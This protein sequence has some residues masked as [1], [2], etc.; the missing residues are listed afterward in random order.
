MMKLAQCKIR[1]LARLMLA[2]VLFAHGIVAAS[3]CVMSSPAQAY[4]MEQHEDEAMPCHEEETPNANACLVHCAQ[5]DQISVDQHSATIA[6]PASLVTWLTPFP[7]IQ[8]DRPK[9]A[10]EHVALDTGPPIPIRFC[11]L[12][13]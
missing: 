13:N 9:I 3:A 2:L 1:W 11:S 5:P 7:Q 12:L 6:V 4:G 10:P 8:Q